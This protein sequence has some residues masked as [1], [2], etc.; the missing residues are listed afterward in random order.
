MHVRLWVPCV[1]NSS[2][3]SLL[4]LVQCTRMYLPILPCDLSF[5]FPTLTQ[6]KWHAHCGVHHLTSHLPPAVVF[7]PKGTPTVVFT[8]SLDTTHKLYLM[9]R[10]ASSNP[11]T[12]AEFSSHVDGRAR[13]AALQVWKCGSV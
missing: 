13:E 1:Q 12:I 4:Q 2:N 7:T 9:L 10:A 8:S 3:H 11:D 6:A 5:Y